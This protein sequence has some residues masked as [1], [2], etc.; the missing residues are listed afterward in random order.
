MKSE[1]MIEAVLDGKEPREVIDEGDSSNIG[2]A[3]THP[4]NSVL[5]A[6]K[7]IN[8]QVG[9]MAHIKVLQLNHVSMGQVIEGEAREV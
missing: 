6:R 5:V 2:Y 9:H 1:Q 7:G 8:V 3:V 4:D